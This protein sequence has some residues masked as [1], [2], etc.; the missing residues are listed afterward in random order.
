MMNF[1][2][3]KSYLSNLVQFFS[4]DLVYFIMFSL[5]GDISVCTHLK[6]TA[7]VDLHVIAAQLHN[8]KQK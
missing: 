2:T 3:G 4:L 5:T 1:L 8:V 6:A 7:S